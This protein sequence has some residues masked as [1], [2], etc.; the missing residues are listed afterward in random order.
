MCRNIQSLKTQVLP[1][2]HGVCER[3]RYSG[4]TKRIIITIHVND[5]PDIFP[6]KDDSKIFEKPSKIYSRWLFNL[7]V[8]LQ[9]RLESADWGLP[10]ASST[11][12]AASPT[13][14]GLSEA[15]VAEGDASSSPIG[16]QRRWLKTGSIAGP[17][18]VRLVI[19]VSGV[20]GWVGGG[21]GGV[22]DSPEFPLLSP[23][24]LSKAP[25]SEGKR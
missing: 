19:R 24:K 22:E 8:S 13:S 18:G 25:G 23:S 20:R 7:V 11:T 15:G 9:E 14:L 5:V 3:E 10:A 4:D 2:L 12:N 21:V 6:T 16:L 1:C 17:R